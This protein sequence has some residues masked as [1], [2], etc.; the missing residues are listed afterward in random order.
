MN[1]TLS[2]STKPTDAELDVLQVLWRLGPATA[3]QV[4]E[5]L[6]ADRD[7]QVVYTTVLKTMQN[8][9][10]KRLLL[11]DESARSHVYQVAA[12]AE[13]LRRSLVKDLVA[14]VFEGSVRDL[15]VSA[16]GARKVS[17]E[18]LSE[19]RRVIQEMEAK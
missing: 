4:W 9:A 11:R 7:K 10:A 1:D 17:P 8:M 19:I 6:N 16:L 14:R 5:V 15:V 18:E 3:R 2:L 13:K 12:P